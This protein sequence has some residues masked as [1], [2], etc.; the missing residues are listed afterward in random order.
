MSSRLSYP[1]VLAGLLVA[2]TSLAGTIY[3]DDSA[4][5]PGNGTSATPYC[6]VQYG[7]NAAVDGDTVLVRYGVYVENLK[8]PCRSVS[9]GP[10]CSCNP[11][12]ST[13]CKRI[14]L[15]GE[16]DPVLGKPELRKASGGIPT[17]EYDL[18]NYAWGSEVATL[19]N[20]KITNGSEG[21]VLSTGA[22]LL[23]DSCDVSGNVSIFDNAAGG[24]T[25]RQSSQ[26][27]IRDCQITENL[28]RAEGGGVHVENSSVRIVDC[29][30][31]QNES[32]SGGGGI[33]VKPV[34]NL[35]VAD[36]VVSGN[37]AKFGGG[38]G[39]PGLGAT[40]ISIKV[41]RCELNG[42]TAS[43]TTG[44]AGGGA[45]FLQGIAGAMPIVDGPNRGLTTDTSLHIVDSI[46]AANTASGVNG[47]FGGGL[48][49]S[50]AEVY[51][52]NCTFYANS[53]SG[54]APR[55]G[56]A[57]WFGPGIIS[58]SPLTTDE[59][60]AN[61]IFWGHATP[62]FGT[63]EG[64]VNY[65]VKV[66]YSNVQTTLSL[67]GTGATGVLDSGGVT[68]E[69]PLFVDE[70]N[71]NFEL[72]AGSPLIDAGNNF[73]VPQDDADADSDGIYDEGLQVDIA[74][75]PR[76]LDHTQT[77]DT[78]FP[79]G[80]CAIVDMG[81]FEALGTYPVSAPTADPLGAPKNRFVPFVTNDP[82]EPMVVKLKVIAS[83]WHPSKV[84]NVY[85]SHGFTTYNDLSTLGTF[86]A[87]DTYCPRPDVSDFAAFGTGPVHHAYGLFGVP[88]ATYEVQFATSA[89]VNFEDSSWDE[90]EWML[91]A[92]LRVTQ[93]EW[94]DVVAP[95]GGGAQP[96]FADVS[97]VVSV[98]QG[99]PVASKTRAKL[100]FPVPDP[101]SPVSLSDVSAAVSAFNGSPFIES[102]MECP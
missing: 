60:I 102:N 23:I 59:V 75:A 97:A 19:A 12:T 26:L 13:N 3:V 88:D 80:A 42:N 87:A 7:I 85:W 70:I 92:P 64:T 15:I 28:G 55:R 93:A 31:T 79:L 61:S 89:C 96:N 21:G 51:L 38:I 16:S 90:R 76:F 54:N 71:G 63:V 56:T 14:H 81:A 66:A 20:F 8:V 94:G 18:S 49:L 29:R 39:T 24:I 84:G 46:I 99:L 43:S 34:S 74:G 58:G 100:R 72:A 77:T 44:V 68:Y 95:F 82:D 78:G 11:T 25:A 30:I 52:D 40:D 83:K 2:H 47:S 10:A 50:T 86:A 17:I 48:H 33:F 5:C 35:E 41:A 53:A 32:P 91:T 73:L 65:I 4:T 67:F 69:N 101:G 62:E 1:G 57:I 37:T 27:L 6:K 22:H 9:G 36:S 98:F 45:V